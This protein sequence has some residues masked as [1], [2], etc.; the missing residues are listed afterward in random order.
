MCVCVC[1]LHLFD[2]H[3]F[4]FHTR[5]KSCFFPMHFRIGI[6]ASARV[7]SLYAFDRDYCLLGS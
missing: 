2:L 4:L 3:F 6:G 1:I 7:I 5:M